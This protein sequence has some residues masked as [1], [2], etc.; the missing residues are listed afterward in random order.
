MSW[1][2]LKGS[3]FERGERERREGRREKEV[4]ES[5]NPS[6]NKFPLLGMGPYSSYYF[7]SN[8]LNLHIYTKNMHPIGF[9]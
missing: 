7:V 4:S 3:Q 6:S 9:L 1:S 2:P 5:E 8:F